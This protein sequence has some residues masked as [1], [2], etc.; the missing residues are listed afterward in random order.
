MCLYIFQKEFQDYM[1][2]ATLSKEKLT[3][4]KEIPTLKNYINGKWV[5]SSSGKTVKNINPANTNE[6]LCNTPLSTREET[7]EAIA[8]AKEAFHKWKSTP[9]PVRGKL[10]FQAMRLLQERIEDV[11]IEIGRAH[12]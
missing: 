10:M 5:S 7:K 8:Y 9:S 11:A 12:V 2:Q 1:Q 4:E 6:V 3:H